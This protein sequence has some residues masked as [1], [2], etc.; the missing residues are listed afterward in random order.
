MKLKL[1]KKFQKNSIELT[2][3]CGSVCVVCV[4][5]LQKLF[6]IY[7]YIYIYIYKSFSVLY[8]EHLHTHIYIIIYIYIFT[9]NFSCVF[10]LGFV[11]FLKITLNYF[12]NIFLLLFLFRFWIVACFLFAI[13]F[14][15]YNLYQSSCVEFHH[16]S[17]A[18]VISI[19]SSRLVAKY[20]FP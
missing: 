20:S 15:I 8:E 3:V 18:F 4:L 16:L 7:L 1:N 10:F 2:F 9:K 12:I 14:P 5:I 19:I 13:K 11:H 6:V 17:F